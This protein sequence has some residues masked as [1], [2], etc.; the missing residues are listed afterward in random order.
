M[1]KIKWEKKK[2]N[3]SFK[4]SILFQIS[5]FIQKALMSTHTN[6]VTSLR[7]CFLLS[8]IMIEQ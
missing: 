2:Q 8:A 4:E 7:K 5:T 6:E 1:I 3:S